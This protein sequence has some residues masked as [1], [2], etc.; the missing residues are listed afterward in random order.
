M[1]YSVEVFGVDPP[2]V[3]VVERLVREST[4]LDTRVD[5]G[6]VEAFGPDEGLLFE[7]GEPVSVDAEE[8]PLGARFPDGEVFRVVL[9][10]ELV[11]VDGKGEAFAR[12]LAGAMSGVVM[13]ETGLSWPGPAAKRYQKAMAAAEPVVEVPAHQLMMWWGGFW[14]EGH[15]P[16][17]ELVGQ[18]GR[19]CPEAM[20]RRYGEYWP[21]KHRFSDGGVDAMSAWWRQSE[22]SSTVA[23]ECVGLPFS[24]GYLA[25]PCA[26]RSVG[27]VWWMTL[28]SAADVIVDEEL[29]ARQRALFT[30]VADL[31]GAVYAFA[32]VDEGYFWN[33]T[34]IG[35]HGGDGEWHSSVCAFS[36][37]KHPEAGLMGLTW[38][39]TWWSWFGGKYRGLLADWLSRPRKA[40]T[41]S[42]TESGV[43]CS[44]RT[45]RSRS[46]S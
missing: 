44:C 3:A 41:V 29:R 17:P 40:W 1:S 28:F 33:G 8:W 31:S 12:V 10:V 16:L 32:E 6:V 42:P 25:V 34:R 7:V 15:A 11:D 37:R 36:G 27:G 30:G 43:L 5:G 26:I 13:D 22:E 39:P 4:G 9:E 19:W 23:Y 20:P 38:Y 14:D 45:S 35:C 21:Y 18:F 24:T 2:G 46:V